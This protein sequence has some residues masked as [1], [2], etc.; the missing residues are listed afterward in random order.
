RRLAQERDDATVQLAA[1]R[2]QNEALRASLVDLPKLRGEV[3]RLREN[4]RELAQLKAVA[5]STGND[6]ALEDAF[7]TWAVR[8][9]RLRQR[10][11]QATGMRIPELQFLT[12]KGW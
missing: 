8:A 10:L 7:K 2:G 4:A 5:D 11:D 12:E 9:T 3:G 6:P 1:I